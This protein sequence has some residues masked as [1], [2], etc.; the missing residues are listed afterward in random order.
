MV[1][2]DEYTT[3]QTFKTHIFVL[4]CRRYAVRGLGYVSYIC[5]SQHHIELSWNGLR[6]QTPLHS[7]WTDFKSAD[8]HDFWWRIRTRD[9]SGIMS[10]FATVVSWLCDWP[11]I[12][13]RHLARKWSLFY[14]SGLMLA[15]LLDSI[16]MEYGTRG[17]EFNISPSLIRSNE[18]KRWPK[19]DK[20]GRPG[21]L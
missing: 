19:K 12:K 15:W 4:C 1:L 9:S 7:A 5:K 20:K 10:R 6:V 16:C 17:G 3:A 2:Q 8:K 11:N 18:N 21:G 14:A 13:P